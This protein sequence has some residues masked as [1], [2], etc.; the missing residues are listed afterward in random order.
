MDLSTLNLTPELMTALEGHI[1]GLTQSE[2]DKI[3]TEYTK[4]MKVTEDELGK[5]RPVT[6]TESE[7]ALDARLKIIEDKEKALS[8]KERLADITTKLNAQGLPSEL[9]KYLQGAE[10]VETD[11][12]SL[13]EMFNGLKIDGSFKPGNHSTGGDAITKEQ[14]GKMSYSERTALYKSNQDLY[15][16]LSKWPKF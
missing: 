1:T 16:R 14:F 11:I 5:Y 13:K 7:I 9:A 10:N 15:E 12:T 6:K 8:G 3:R 2:G 4:K